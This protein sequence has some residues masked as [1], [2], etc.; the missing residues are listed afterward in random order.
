MKNEPSSTPSDLLSKWQSSPKFLIFL[1]AE[2]LIAHSHTLEQV[3][4]VVQHLLF[5]PGP[6][7]RRLG[8]AFA[9]GAEMWAASKKGR[10]T[11]KTIILPVPT[12]RNLWEMRTNLAIFYYPL[13]QRD[14]LWFKRS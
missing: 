2:M 13:V 3:G 10:G 14:F 4:L 9:A 6:P 8:P 11:H 12:A 7:P 5:P 1:P